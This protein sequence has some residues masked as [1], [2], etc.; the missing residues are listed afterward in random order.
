MASPEIKIIALSNVYSRLMHFL[1]KGDIENG[2]KHTYDHATLVSSGSVLVEVLDELTGEPISS[3]TFSSPN[4]VF[5]HK[6]KIHRLI[7]LEDNTVCSC[8]HAIRTIEDEIVDSDFLIEPVWS[9]EKGEVRS[10]VQEKYNKEMLSFAK[11]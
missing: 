7:A 3:K 11:G 1:K 5:I 4:M 6:D 10:L 2:H 9:Q 8:I